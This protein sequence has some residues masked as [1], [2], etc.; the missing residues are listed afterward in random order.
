MLDGQR[1][2]LGLRVR[3]HGLQRSAALNGCTGRVCSW[4]NERAGALLDSKTTGDTRL[5]VRL[6]KEVVELT[7]AG[8]DTHSSIMWHLDL[9]D[10]LSCVCA[11]K[12]LHASRSEAVLVPFSV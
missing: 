12:S 7:T 1:R 6:V 4:Q 11:C 9:L 2:L 5:A 8:S 3:L 10:M